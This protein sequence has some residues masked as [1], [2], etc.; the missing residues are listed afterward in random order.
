MA[1]P[2]ISDDK[3]RKK[4]SFTIDP[5][6]YDNWVTYCEENEIINQSVFIEKMINEKIMKK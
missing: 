6:V 3:K 2:K 4:I 1:R 5:K